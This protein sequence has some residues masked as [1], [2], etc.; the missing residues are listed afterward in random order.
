MESREEKAAERRTPVS[1]W[2]CVMSPPGTSCPPALIEFTTSAIVRPSGA[3]RR[4]SVATW[5]S[6][7]SPPTTRTVAT[8]GTGSLG[9][10][11]SSTLEQSTVDVATELTNMIQSQSGYQSNGQAL[12]ASTDMMKVLTALNIG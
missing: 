10:L 6:R 8:P 4:A 5:I 3:R 2:D 7:C 12:K 1:W 11:S 9:T